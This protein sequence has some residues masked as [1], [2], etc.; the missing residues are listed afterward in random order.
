LKRGKKSQREKGETKK[1]C[2]FGARVLAFTLGQLGE[3]KRK[4]KEKRVGAREGTPAKLRDGKAAC[5]VQETKK[6]R[7]EVQRKR[8]NQE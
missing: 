6:R 1:Q 5:L 7:S 3:K 8:E 4:W 2:L